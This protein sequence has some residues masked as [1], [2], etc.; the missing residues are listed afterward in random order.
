MAAEVYYELDYA[1]LVLVQVAVAEAEVRRPY[2]ASSISLEQERALVQVG[3][4]EE[5]QTSHRT[6]Q[7]RAQTNRSCR[8]SGKRNERTLHFFVR[9][10]PAACLLR[11]C[12]MEQEA[13]SKKVPV[14][15]IT[16][17]LGAGKV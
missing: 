16:G 9:A 4:E 11:T 7:E 10:P 1:D 14:T 13:S 12:E 15:I 8:G 17:F 5:A 2:P 3:E 6:R